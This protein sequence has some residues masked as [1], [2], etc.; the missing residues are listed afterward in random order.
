M[1]T[2]LII[3]S[4]S[5][6]RKQWRRVAVTDWIVIGVVAFIVAVALVAPLIAP[7]NIY[8][9]DV[10]NALLPPSAEHW[11]GTDA[12]GRDVLWR[13]AVGTQ[14][15]LFSATLVVACY[16]LIGMVVATL[17]SVGGKL[18]DD[19]LM[20]ATDIVFALPVMVVGLGFA[21][22]LGPSL[23]SAIVA[24]ILVGW[25]YSAR[26]LRSVTRQTMVMPFI[27]GATVLGV[28]RFRLMVRHVLPNSLDI[29]VVKWFADIGLTVML[30]S[31]L[32]F[33]GVGAQAPSAEWGAMVADARSYVA[34]AWWTAAAPG[35]AITITVVAFGLLGDLVQQRRNPLE[36][37]M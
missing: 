30:L 5:R 8:T 31:S 1:T 4:L 2:A 27:E 23:E 26:V 22:A 24:M 17:A 36:R 21:A 15:S 6:Q 10:R 29:M 14:T 7:D 3:S 35:L 37:E 25:P 33:L 34:T 11:M 12:L 20:R 9:P 13:V 18:I 28:S 32:S 19:L 16:A